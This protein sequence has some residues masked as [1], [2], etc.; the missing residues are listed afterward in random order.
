MWFGCVRSSLVAMFVV[1]ITI[2]LHI[3]VLFEIGIGARRVWPPDETTVITPVYSVN[4]FKIF[5]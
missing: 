1:N 4:R 5:F 3:S 2:D